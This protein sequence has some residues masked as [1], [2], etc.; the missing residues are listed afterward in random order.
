MLHRLHDYE[1]F[2]VHA[3][4]GELGSVDDFLFDDARWTV[5][6]LVVGTGSLFGRRVAISPIAVVEPDWKA[7]RLAIRLSM[8]R[9]REGPD[10]LT[11][12]DIPRT[13]EEEYAT[14]YGYPAY[15]GGPALWA[16][17]GAPGALAGTPPAEYMVPGGTEDPKTLAQ[18]QYQL[19]SVADLRGAHLHA[20]DGEIG[21]VDDLLIDAESWNAPYLLIDTSNW[22]GGKRVLVPTAAI[23]GVGWATHTVH[24]DLPKVRIQEAPV[25]DLDGPLDHAA[26]TALAAYY[27]RTRT[28]PQTRGSS[29][30]SH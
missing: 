11:A 17:A 25:P 27:D 7:K 26:E 29:A 22:I 30:G 2:T 24:I 9:I 5:R 15:W 28:A 18:H 16:W 19:R 12:T 4:N 23:T 10:L 1:Q 3:T 14:Y 20:A 21:H 6:Y 8:E 13:R